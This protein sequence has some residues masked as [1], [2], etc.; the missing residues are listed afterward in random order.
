M[1][2]WRSSPC[3]TERSQRSTVDPRGDACARRRDLRFEGGPAA[4]RPTAMMNR[5]LRELPASGAPAPSSWENYV[6]AV[7]EWIRAGPSRYAEHR[8]AGVEGPVRGD[9]LRSAHEHPAVRRTPKSHVTIK[10][11]EPDF[12]ELFRKGLRA[13]PPGGS[14]DTGFHGREMTRNAAIGDLALATGLRRLQ[15][16]TYLLPWENPRCRPRRPR[17]RSRS[18]RQPRSPEARSSAP[19]G[20]PTRPSPRCTTTW[21]RTGPSPPGAPGGGRRVGWSPRTAISACRR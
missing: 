9:D 10:Y 21:S 8:A 18:R 20:S 6:R 3:W 12:A 13:L 7:K 16:L 4:P 19:P 1:T 14:Q 17:C 11:L 5:W 15:G 2:S